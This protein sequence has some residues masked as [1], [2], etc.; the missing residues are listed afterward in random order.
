MFVKAGN[1]KRYFQQVN[2]CFIQASDYR[3][4]QKI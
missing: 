4:T 1:Y 3:V 2:L